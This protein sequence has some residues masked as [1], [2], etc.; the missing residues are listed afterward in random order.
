MNARLPL[1]F[2]DSPALY[3]IRSLCCPEFTSGTRHHSLPPT[4]SIG[5]VNASASRNDP[6]AQPVRILPY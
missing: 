4:E 2:A 5:L 6:I 1:A 3:S